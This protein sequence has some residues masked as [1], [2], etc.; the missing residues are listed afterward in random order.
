MPTLVIWGDD[1]FIPAEIATHIARAIP[2]ARLVTVK[3]CGHFAYLECPADVRA[4]F[5]DFFS[6]AAGR[7]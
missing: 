2:R 3:D 7:K 1:D 4:A 5:N 6:G